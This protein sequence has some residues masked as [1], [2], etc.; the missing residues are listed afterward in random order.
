MR[1]KRRIRVE[2]TEL[3]EIMGAGIVDIEVCSDDWKEAYNKIVCL[4]QNLI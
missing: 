2:K 3:L 4:V 1:C